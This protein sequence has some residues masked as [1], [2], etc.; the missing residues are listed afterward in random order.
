MCASWLHTHYHSIPNHT[1]SQHHQS[2]THTIT[3]HTLQLHTASPITH[4]HN[5]TDHTPSQHHQ[6]HTITA[7]PITH[8]LVSTFSSR[9]RSASWTTHDLHPLLQKN[10][11]SWEWVWGH[12]YHCRGMLPMVC[13]PSELEV[14]SRGHSHP[15]SSPLRPFAAVDDLSHG[16]YDVNLAGIRSSCDPTSHHCPCG[17]R[18]PH[19][20][21]RRVR[22]G[23]LTVSRTRGSWRD[24]DYS[25]EPFHWSVHWRFCFSTAESCR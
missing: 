1:P 11:C 18:D 25:Y 22:G 17:C 21:W 24:W 10:V 8:S 5:I 9:H 13:G 16:C 23:G 4:Y 2:H 7:S 3:N 14:C 6:S 15:S 19:W 20:D 12:W